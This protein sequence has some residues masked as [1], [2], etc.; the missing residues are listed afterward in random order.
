MESERP[1]V[2]PAAARN[3]GRLLAN[4]DDVNGAKRAYQ[5]AIESRDPKWPRWQRW[6][7]LGFF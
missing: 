4:R 3:L 5:V 2:L 1:D 7:L 6:N